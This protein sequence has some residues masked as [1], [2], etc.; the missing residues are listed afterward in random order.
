[1]IHAIQPLPIGTALRLFLSPPAGASRWKILRKGADSF[2]G[3]DDAAAILVHEGDSKVVLDARFLRN[4]IAA[5]YRPYYWIGGA[6]QPGATTSGT[7]AAIYEDASTDVQSIVRQRLEDGL[8]EEVRRGTLKNELG[9]V[10]V[11]SAPPQVSDDLR[12]PLVTVELASEQPA[13]RG[14]G[15]GVIPDAFDPDAF[16][17][18]DAE[19]WLSSVSLQVIGWSLNPDERIALR[20]AL[21]RLVIG[22]L[23]VFDDAGMVQ[24]EFSSQDVDLIN[25]EFA[26]PLY[27]CL[28][29]FSCMAP[30]IVRSSVDAIRDVESDLIQP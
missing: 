25:G 13:V 2:S 15:E 11:F 18:A 10:Q 19:G 26:A 9:Y 7:P 24:I 21:R 16:E 30:A 12:F 1:M 23:P 4:G 28:C 22:N 29:T 14:I 17:W 20:N 27:Q 8:A 3:P 5:F 6:W